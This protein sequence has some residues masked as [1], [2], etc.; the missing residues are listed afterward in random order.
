MNDWVTIAIFI[1]GILLGIIIAPYP[2]TITLQITDNSSE[3]TYM[4]L[5][6]TMSE[7]ESNC[8]DWKEKSATICVSWE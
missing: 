2:A 4:K 7:N 5:T 6:H 8:Y 1:S 3:D